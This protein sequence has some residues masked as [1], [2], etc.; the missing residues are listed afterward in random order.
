MASAAQLMPIVSKAA[1][2]GDTPSSLEFHGRMTTSR[3]IEP[4]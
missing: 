3:K 2:Y 1:T 4:T